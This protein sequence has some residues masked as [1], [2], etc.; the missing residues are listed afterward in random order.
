MSFSCRRQMTDFRRATSPVART[1][2]GPNPSESHYDG[3]DFIDAGEDNDI[4]FA[5]DARGNGQHELPRRGDQSCRRGS[6][7][8]DVLLS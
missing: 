2:G 4:V 1:S 5:D 3:A 7:I 6:D 8:A